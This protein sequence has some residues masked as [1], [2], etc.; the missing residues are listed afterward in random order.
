ISNIAKHLTD[1]QAKALT[2]LQLNQL[3]AE[4]L[5]T[6]ADKLSPAQIKSLTPGQLNKLDADALNKIAEHLTAG[7]IQSLTTTQLQKLSSETLK[8][9]LKHLT[10]DQLRSL[11]QS[12]IQGLPNDKIDYIISEL[13]EKD[14]EELSKKMSKD[15]IKYYIDYKKN[16]KD[17]PNAILDRYIKDNINSQMDIDAKH[18]TIDKKKI[19]NNGL[20]IELDKQGKGGWIINTTDKGFDIESKTDEN[21]LNLTNPIDNSS[22]EMSLDKGESISVEYTI[23]EEFAI[24]LDDSFLRFDII[25]EGNGRLKFYSKKDGTTLRIGSGGEYEFHDGILS[26][27]NLDFEEKLDT[28]ALATIKIDM[29][30]GFVCM[31]LPKGSA[32]TFTNTTGDYKFTDTI[33]IDGYKLCVKK[34]DY[35]TDDFFDIFLKYEKLT[36]NRNVGYVNMLKD[37]HQYGSLLDFRFKDF[38][39]YESNDVSEAVFDGPIVKISE[40]APKKITRTKNFEILENNNRYLKISKTPL[41]KRD[42]SQYK[43]EHDSTIYITSDKLTQISNT[44]TVTALTPGSDEE[45]RYI[46]ELK[47]EYS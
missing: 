47:A 41:S 22:I 29:N 4:A 5:N 44:A 43:T 2:A 28:D 30:A 45:K 9:I 23:E 40:K 46:L 37:Y 21:T 14:H 6:L 10:D 27:M 33:K 8:K 17:I 32:Y 11:T 39:T 26:Y 24:K 35:I 1:A 15:Q 34:T 36:G 42:I 20:T 3:S 12:Q 38:D 25:P 16:L 7:Q 18:G 31:E 13:P 19:T